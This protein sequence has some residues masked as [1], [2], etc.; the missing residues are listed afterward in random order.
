MMEKHKKEAKGL[1]KIAKDLFLS[2]VFEKTRDGFIFRYID[3]VG[4][5]SI[6]SPDKQPI[7]AITLDEN[8]FFQFK[9]KVICVIKGA[10]SLL[11]LERINAYIKEVEK[12][13]SPDRA[14]EEAG[15]YKNVF[16]EYFK[17]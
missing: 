11:F 15:Y 16:L 14:R 3:S 4:I 10:G 17:E 9:E 13:N 5:H 6:W 8:G 12:Q 7:E 2:E 1:P